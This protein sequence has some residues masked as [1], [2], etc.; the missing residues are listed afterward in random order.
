[1]RLFR[2]VSDIISA[3]LNDLVDRFEEPEAML[4]QAIREMDDNVSQTTA[5]AAKAIAGETLL[6]KELAEHG[7]QSEQW[8]GRAVK[9]V[10][11]GDDALARKALARKREHETLARALRD[12][13]AAAHEASESLRRQVDAMK[14]KHSEARRKLATLTARLRAADARQKLRGTLREDPLSSN[15]FAT[16]ERLRERVELAEAEAVALSGLLGE[17]GD[18]MAAEIEADEEGR[19][20]EDELAAIKQALRK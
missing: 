5:A 16:F 9:A 19:R 4:R 15:G 6:A 1:M 12:Q 7:R 8:H 10:E 13:W 3:N 20:L 17:E 14:A 11:A 2:R 18:E